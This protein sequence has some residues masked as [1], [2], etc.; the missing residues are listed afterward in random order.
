MYNLQTHFGFTNL[1]R[2]SKIP[3]YFKNRFSV[4]IGFEISKPVLKPVFSN[5]MKIAIFAHFLRQNNA[6]SREN[7]PILDNFVLK[8]LIVLTR[9]HVTFV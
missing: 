3:I 8:A 5:C 6:F 4:L 1:C 2:E 7:S 9:L